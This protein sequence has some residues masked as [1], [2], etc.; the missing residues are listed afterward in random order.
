[1]SGSMLLIG[2]AGASACASACQ[3]S[4]RF[5]ALP[6]RL[7][8]DRKQ[9]LASPDVE[10]AVGDRRRGHHGFAEVVFSQHFVRRT[11]RQHEAVT[12]FVGDINLVATGDGG[13]GEAA[14]STAETL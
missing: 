2:G 3:L 10:H 1:M 8:A 5:S 14:R 7:D 12:L 4:R 13:A 6:S 11:G 9:V